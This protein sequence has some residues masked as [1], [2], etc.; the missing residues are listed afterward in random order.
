MIRR[1][2]VLQ[3]S[4]TLKKLPAQPPLQ[5]SWA[6]HKRR[7]IA[8]IARIPGCRRNSYDETLGCW[9]DGSVIHS[10]NNK[11]SETSHIFVSCSLHCNKA[12]FRI[13]RTKQ[14]KCHGMFEAL[15]WSSPCEYRRGSGASKGTLGLP[16]A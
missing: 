10:S 2:K 5:K 16:Q 1:F 6:V 13:R 11:N 4:L 3:G 8:W 15:Q 7:W 12:D 9:S 14:P